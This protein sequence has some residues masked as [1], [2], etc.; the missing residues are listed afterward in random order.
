MKTISKLHIAAIAALII[1]P[2]YACSVESEPEL[3]AGSGAPPWCADLLDAHECEV[4][5][6]DFPAGGCGY[7]PCICTRPDDSKS[8][9]LGPWYGPTDPECGGDGYSPDAAP[10]DAAD[11]EWR[12]TATLAEGTCADAPTSFEWTVPVAAPSVVG[13]PSWVCTFYPHDGCGHM[14]LCT[15]GAVGNEA[16]YIFESDTLRITREVDL[17]GGLRCKDSFD[18]EWHERAVVP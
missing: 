5:E 16:M 9:C 11:D 12:F 18:V 8:L 13:D 14:L 3:D 6:C 2:C 1:G 15:G 4:L 7:E 17:G 10:P